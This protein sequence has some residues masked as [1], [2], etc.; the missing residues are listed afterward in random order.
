[1]YIVIATIDDI[2]PY[3]VETRFCLCRKI[4]YDL[5]IAKKAAEDYLSAME[6][7]KWLD[8]GWLESNDRWWGRSAQAVDDSQDARLF[9]DWDIYKVEPDESETLERTFTTIGNAVSY[10]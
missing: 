6:K 10:K 3:G 8:E 5:E 7:W 9:L 1:M 4:F 2:V